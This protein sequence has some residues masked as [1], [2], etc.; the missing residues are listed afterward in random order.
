MIYWKIKCKFENKNVIYDNYYKTTNNEEQKAIHNLYKMRNSNVAPITCASIVNGVECGCTVVVKDYTNTRGQ[1]ELAKIKS[2][3]HKFGCPSECEL[4]EP[5]DIIDAIN[6]EQLIKLLSK[7]DEKFVAGK[8]NSLG[9]F[10]PVLD[11]SGN[12]EKEK[13]I[14]KTRNYKVIDVDKTLDYIFLR[15]D[16][17]GKSVPTS[18]FENERWENCFRSWKKT[19]SMSPT[20]NHLFKWNWASIV[21]LKNYDGENNYINM[22]IHK[23]YFSIFGIGR[24]FI[25]ND[26]PIFLKIVIPKD[27]TKED[28]LE[29][30]KI[31]KNSSEKLTLSALTT[32]KIS[33]NIKSVDDLNNFEFSDIKLAQIKLESSSLLVVNGTNWYKKFKDLIKS[34][35]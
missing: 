1:Y 13:T 12:E 9:I 17:E 8:V 14:K 34:K 25:T 22:P 18:D 32:A 35:K 29:V 24:T 30:Q 10:V 11:T 21:D 26:N 23:I 28:W 31:A 19:D 6:I 20:N 33:H 7:K 15:K 16:I 5:K 2:D 4:F 27:I 3:S